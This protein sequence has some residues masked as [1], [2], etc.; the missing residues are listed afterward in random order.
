DVGRTYESIIRVNSQSGKG[1]ISYLLEAEYGLVLP[2]R[3]QVEFS[4]AVQKVTD[5]TG[6]EVTAADIWSIFESEYL[7]DTSPLEYVGHTLY[8]EDGKQGVKLRIRRFDKDEEVSGLGN[9]PID[10]FMH[11]LNVPV[12]VRHYDEHS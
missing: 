3:L 4:A 6:K 12:Q 1:G 5:D 8:D 2:R 11:A 7:A 9:G 10:A